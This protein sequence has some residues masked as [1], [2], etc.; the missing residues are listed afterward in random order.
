MS[1]I[2]R[3]KVYHIR[4]RPFDGTLITV[5]T[6]AESKTRAMQ[7]ERAIL[8]A[9]HARDYRALNPEERAVCIS[10]FENRRWEIPSDLGDS[11]PVKEE[12]TLWRAVEIFLNY[13]GIKES[14]TKERYIYALRHVIGWI[15]KDKPI[16]SLWV[17]EIRL[18]QSNRLT[19]GASPSTINKECGTLSRLF[20]V[21]VELQFLDANPV[22]LVK[23]LS[24]KSG[25]RQ[26]YLSFQ[27]VHRI[28]DGTSDWFKRFVLTAYYTGARRGELM[29]L[30]RKQVDLAGRIMRFGPQDTKERNWKRVPI[31]RDLIPVL[32]ECSK[33]RSF[34]TDKF[35]LMQDAN[36]TRPVHKEAIK[37]QWRRRVDKLGFDPAPHLHDLRHT[38]RTNARRSGVNEQIAESIMGHWFKGKSVNDRYGY[39]SDQELVQTID[40][41]TFD[42]GETVIWASR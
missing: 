11:K 42:N 32:E 18:Y 40:R 38:W 17:P 7:I 28:I 34:E 3:G 14:P 33:V 2:K 5:R 23:K 1:V 4:F 6:P 41:M 13:P 8:T 9:C 21:L 12:L 19:E 31:H 20:G 35:F 30:T 29:S 26:V 24:E 36:G 25:Q 39:I 16:K 22:R 37:S 15:G 27:D 10:M